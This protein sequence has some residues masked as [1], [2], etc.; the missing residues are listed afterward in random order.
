VAA[1]GEVLSED[2]YWLCSSAD[3][4]GAEWRDTRWTRVDELIFARNLFLGGN[5]SQPAA[6]SINLRFDPNFFVSPD[7]D[8]A[9]FPEPNR[10]VPRDPLGRWHK[11]IRTTVNL[12]IGTEDGASFEILGHANFF[13]VRGDSANIPEELKLL[14]SKPDSTRWYIRRWDDETGSS[15]GL[16]GDLRSR[17]VTAIARRPG[18]L[19]AQPSRNATWCALKAA[20]R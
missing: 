18:A 3:S 13:V 16:S 1:Y 19:R 20:Y 2:F 4:A 10:T 6:S 14:G 15:G 17:A 9:F 11:N 5:A 7:P 8:Y 12:R